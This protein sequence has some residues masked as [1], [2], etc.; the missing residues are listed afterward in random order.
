MSYRFSDGYFKP[1]ADGY[2][3]F[4]KDGYTAA[5]TFDG[6]NIGF[7]TNSATV[8][9]SA[10]GILFLANRATAPSAVPSGGGW[11]YSEQGDGYWYNSSGS[12]QSISNTRIVRAFPTDANYT[13]VQ[14]DYQANIMEFTGTISTTR[15][16]VV[17]ILSTYQWTV[18]NNTTGGQSIQI[19]GSTGTGITI[20]NGK[21]AIVYSDGTNVQRV[22]PDT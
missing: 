2:V 8:E 20:A 21:R 19:I 3:R 9:D 17:P 16:V 14:A 10:R 1:N 18:F 4:F 22:T 7:F 11:L 12:I 13:A 5:F 15:N 6:Y